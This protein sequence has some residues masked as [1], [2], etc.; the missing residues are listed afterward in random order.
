MFEFSLLTEVYWPSQLMRSRS[1]LSKLRT[2]LIKHNRNLCAWSCSSFHS[3]FS[4]DSAT[5]HL[6]SIDRKHVTFPKRKW[7]YCGMVKK[8]TDHLHLIWRRELIQRALKCRNANALCGS[9][10]SRWFIMLGRRGEWRSNAAGREGSGNAGNNNNNINWSKGWPQRFV[11]EYP[12]GRTI[13][14]LLGVHPFDLVLL[15]SCSC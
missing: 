5:W 3:R 13:Q 10:L 15:K 2:A 7:C 11:L 9:P 8:V 6:L 1:A 14:M 4:L 12:S